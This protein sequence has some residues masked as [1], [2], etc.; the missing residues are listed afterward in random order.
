MA[1]KLTT[2]LMLVEAHRGEA[3]ADSQLVARKFRMKH[4]YFARVIDAVLDDYPDLRVTSNHPKSAHSERFYTEVRTYRGQHYTAYLMNRPFF[5]L[6]AMRCETAKAREWQRK[7]NAAY[8]SMECA[9]LNLRQNASD[10]ALIEQRN[11]GKVVRCGLT[12]TIQRFV[13]Y[14]TAQGSA[15]A[16]FYFKNITSATYRALGLVQL[17]SIS[18]RDTLSGLDQAWLITAES[19]AESKL[20]EYMDLGTPY[21]LI[22]KRVSDDL[23]A[24]CKPLVNLRTSRLNISA[25]RQQP[26]ARP[27]EPHHA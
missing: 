23:M 21:K 17:K 6:V 7:F 20:H 5:A 3:F 18:L 24:F 10:S 1:K 8:F 16:K 12:D 13:D 9:L 14:A 2:D 11:N 15:G 26:H 25:L 27:Q 4:A 22:F 19:F